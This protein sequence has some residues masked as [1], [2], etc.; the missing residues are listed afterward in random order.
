[1]DTEER[2][3]STVRVLV[4]DDD[5]LY[6]EALAV[7]LAEYDWIE[8]V[9][10]ARNGADA[11]VRTLARQPDVVVMDGLMPRLDGFEAT[12]FL[13]EG[14]PAT[15]VVIVT[16]SQDPADERRAREAGA[17][18]FVRKGSAHDR[19]ADAILHAAFA[20]SGCAA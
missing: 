12:R 10:R 11:V 19:L 1:M 2:R 3:T 7:A 14:Q 20:P 18:G 17:V 8:I 9:D 13:L 6:A 4:A 15:R 16:S 5:D